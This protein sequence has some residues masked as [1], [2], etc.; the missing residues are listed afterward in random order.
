M[1]CHF[2]FHGIFPIHRWNSRLL[3]WQESSLPLSHLGSH[4]TMYKR[5]ICAMIVNMILKGVLKYWRK[6][7]NTYFNTIQLP[8]MQRSILPLLLLSRSSRV[9]FCVTPKTADHLAPLS[10][11]FS[12][13]EH[14]SGCH[15][16]LQCMK[17][18]SESEVT[19]SCPT[20]SDPMDCSLPG[21]STH[22]IFQARV[23]E[24]GAIAFSKVLSYLMLNAKNSSSHCCKSYTGLAT[25]IAATQK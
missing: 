19:Q 23:L 16:L 24:W 3:R 18:K 13:Q 1:G 10:L 8:S 17:V 15:F 2:L 9:R 4:S 21:S 25:V 5:K 11:G 12:R 20:P 22:G 14:W 6:L 7:M